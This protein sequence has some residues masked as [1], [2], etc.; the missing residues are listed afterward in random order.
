MP[1]NSGQFVDGAG[2]EISRLLKTEC[3]V[4][5]GYRTGKMG[6]GILVHE[7]CCFSDCASHIALQCYLHSCCTLE[8]CSMLVSESHGLT[9][10]QREGRCVPDFYVKC[11]SSVSSNQDTL[12]KK[13]CFHLAKDLKVLYTVLYMGA[14]GYYQYQFHNSFSIVLWNVSKLKWA[15]V[16]HNCLSWMEKKQKSPF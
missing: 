4:I 9:P 13:K 3:N 1:T 16:C 11:E 5:T 12:K 2:A 14:A 6:R 8:F 15:K 10:R 7:W